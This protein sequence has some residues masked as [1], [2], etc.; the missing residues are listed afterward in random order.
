M[1]KVLIGTIIAIIVF[2]VGCSIILRF[3]APDMDE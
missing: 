1:K 2:I 3:A